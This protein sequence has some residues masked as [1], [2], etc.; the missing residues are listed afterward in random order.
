MLLELINDVFMS[1][2]IFYVYFGAIFLTI[3]VRQLYILHHQGW[4]SDTPFLLK[5][6][7]YIKIDV[8]SFEQ[9]MLM[10]ELFIIWFVKTFKRIDK[11]DDDKEDDSFSYFKRYLKIRGGQL[12]KQTA[13]SPPYGNIGLV[14]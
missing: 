14:F 13:Y 3:G 7:Q 12:W 5:Q 9:R 2:S 8:D 11:P 1:S 6:H 4:K 10:N